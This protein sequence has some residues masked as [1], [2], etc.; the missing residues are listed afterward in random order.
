MS[1]DPLAPPSDGRPIQRL[2]LAA[3][4]PPREENRD[5]EPNPVSGPR[6]RV[7]G[8]VGFPRAVADQ[9]AAAH[10][11]PGRADLPLAGLLRG[12]RDRLLR[13]PVHRPLPPAPVRLQRRRAALDLAGALLR[14]PGAGPPPGSARHPPP[15][16]GA[17]P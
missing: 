14:V 8:R 16:A 11:P 5:G 9:V 4:L 1:V 2:T 15:P 3:R 6:R 10:P 17:P 13:D 7:A 12:H